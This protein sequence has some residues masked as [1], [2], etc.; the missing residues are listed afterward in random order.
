[1]STPFATRMFTAALIAFSSNELRSQETQPYAPVYH[2]WLE[3][4]VLFAQ[5]TDLHGFPGAGGAA[6]LTLDPGFRIAGGSD[7]SFTRYL[8]VG[9]EVGVLGAGVEGASRLEEMDAVITQVPFLVNVALRYEN[10]S[11]FTPFIGIAGG[12]ASTALDVDEAR[13]GTATVDGSDFDF[14]PA[15]QLTAG[16]KYEFKNHIGLGLTYKY[17]WTGNA[18]WEL[19]SDTSGVPDQDL[20]LD[21]IHSHAV[22]AFISYQ[23]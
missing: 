18:E 15:W 4:G 12:A 19:E 20:R 8:S 3:A 22:L 7:Y 6:R 11:G 16:M 1:M 21:G 17:L 10:A 2:A 23:F 5:S 13:S 9:W 14:V